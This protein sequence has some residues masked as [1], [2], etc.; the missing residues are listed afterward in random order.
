M[1]QRNLHKMAYLIRGFLAF[2]SN[3]QCYGKNQDIVCDNVPILCIHMYH[4]MAKNITGGSFPFRRTKNPFPIF[5][6]QKTDD[7]VKQPPNG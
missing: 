2:G 4:G 5:R 6:A 7:F 1:S 3:D